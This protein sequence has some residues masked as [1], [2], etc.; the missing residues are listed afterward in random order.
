MVSWEMGT[1]SRMMMMEV[2]ASLNTEPPVGILLPPPRSPPPMFTGSHQPGGFRQV[3]Q[4]KL[5]QLV[6]EGNVSSRA[7]EDMEGEPF[8]RRRL[9]SE[10]LMDLSYT[11]IVTIVV[12]V[13]VVLLHYALLYILR[14]CSRREVHP[15]LHLPRFETFLLGLLMLIITFYACKDLSSRH[16][17]G[18][19]ALAV[20]LVLPLPFTAL[21]WW[22][23]LGVCIHGLKDS[24]ARVNRKTL[25]SWGLANPD[26]YKKGSEVWKENSMY[27]SERLSEPEQHIVQDT[28]RERLPSRFETQLQGFVRDSEIVRQDADANNL[29]HLA[30]SLK[31][32]FHFHAYPPNSTSPLPHS[33]IA[34]RQDADANN[35]IHLA[36][37]LKKHVHFHAY[38]PDST[39]PLPHSCIAV[40]HD[41]EEEDTLSPLPPTPTAAAAAAGSS[42]GGLALGAAEAEGGTGGDSGCQ[43]DYTPGGAAGGLVLGAAAAKGGTGGDAGAHIVSHTTGVQ[44]AA[45]SSV[46]IGIV[47]DG[48]SDGGRTAAGTV[49]SR[50]SKDSD[51]SDSTAS[52]AGSANG[53]ISSAFRVMRDASIFEGD[54]YRQR[55]GIPEESRGLKPTQIARPG[56][57]RRTPNRTPA[58]RP[59][60]HSSSNLARDVNKSQTMRSLNRTPENPLA[61]TSSS[62]SLGRG[63]NISQTLRSLNRTPEN[64]LARTSSSSSLGR[65]M[66]ISQTLRSLNRT[67]EN[68]LARTSSSSSLGRGMNISQTLRSLNRS[69]EKPLAHT[70]DSNR[71]LTNFPS[72]TTSL[73]ASSYTSSTSVGGSSVCSSD[74]GLEVPIY[75]D[76]GPASTTARSAGQ[77]ASWAASN[78]SVSASSRQGLGFKSIGAV[79]GT[80]KER[81]TDSMRAAG[82]IGEATEV[83]EWHSGPGL[84]GDQAQ[85]TG[86]PE[87]PPMPRRMSGWAT[88]VSNIATRAKRSEPKKVG[89]PRPMARPPNP[90]PMPSMTKVSVW[91][92]RVS[93]IATRAGRKKSSEAKYR[94]RDTQNGQEGGPPEVGAPLQRVNPLRTHI[95]KII[96]RESKLKRMQ[97]PQN[98]QEGGGAKREVPKG[99]N[100]FRT[101][102][103]QFISRQSQFKKRSSRAP[104]FPPATSTTIPTLN[105]SFPLASSSIP[106]RS[107]RFRVASPSSYHLS[108]NFP[109]VASSFNLLGMPGARQV[110][111]K[112]PARAST[113]TLDVDPGLDAGATYPRARVSTVILDVDPVLDKAPPEA[114]PPW[115]GWEQGWKGNVHWELVTPSTA[116]RNRFLFVF[117]DVTEE[118]VTPSTAMRN[119]FLFVFEDVA[120]DKEE[121]EEGEGHTP[122]WRLIAPPLSTTHKLASAAILGSCSTCMHNVGQ[123]ATLFTLQMLMLLYLCI[124][125]P[126]F[127]WYLQMMETVLHTSMLALCGTALASRGYKDALHIARRAR[128]TEMQRMLREALEP[129]AKEKSGIST[130]PPVP[131]TTACVRS[132]VTGRPRSRSKID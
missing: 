108:L 121:E 8:Q 4:N 47:G 62:S 36:T 115:E 76:S 14:R 98:G 58:G 99:G 18:V 88:R 130:A 63:M 107:S 33:C 3:N 67:P 56:I 57:A 117:E 26:G 15:S 21:L 16:Q 82:P 43:D 81:G 55:S 37:S 49:G 96:S 118:L 93:N 7:E 24:T 10:S 103:S 126:Y 31:K 5:R 78:S 86:P 9:H 20:L 44:G 13:V 28:W 61:R 113:D 92:N 90:P 77:Q 73:G 1:V 105:P 97:D 116:M 32:H 29:I 89:G 102:V 60:M 74:A 84:T 129:A 19:P 72:K 45:G 114:T 75:P 12:F 122:W 41:D 80:N 70:S 30:T 59:L 87:L 54:S 64:P 111:E 25:E 106:R 91:A 46:H 11:L 101:H 125:K 53:G 109:R 85:D 124:A 48:G 112:V 71:F 27:Q 128:H 6:G 127:K 95:S 104:I 42:G 120:E 34:V 22:L 66:N 40:R 83:E 123:V 39:S 69:P 17:L 51:D 2:M 50:G 35:L 131:L 119:R 79:S 110:D 38:P 65:G 132:G 94:V 68:P 52:D 100:P 23:T